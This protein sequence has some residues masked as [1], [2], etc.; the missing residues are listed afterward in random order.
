MHHLTFLR[1]IESAGYQWSL[2]GSV[3]YLPKICFATSRDS[4][5]NLPSSTHDGTWCFRL[6]LRN[7]HCN[8]SALLKF[9]SMNFTFSTLQ[10]RVV[11]C[12]NRAGG[13]KKNL[14]T[15]SPLL[16]R[17]SFGNTD[18]K[19]CQLLWRSNASTNPAAIKKRN[20]A[21]RRACE[22]VRLDGQQP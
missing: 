18:L 6:I 15:V 19:V 11:M 2:L 17:L 16:E 3:L 9:I 14:K 21:A 8:C 12:T 22:L 5:I 10:R 4:A 7:H 20:M 1:W 13:E